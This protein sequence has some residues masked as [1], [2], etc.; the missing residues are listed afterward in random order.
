MP[1]SQRYADER[2]SERSDD[3]RDN[4]ERITLK[5]HGTSLGPGLDI[6]RPALF[7]PTPYAFTYSG[8]R[9]LAFAMRQFQA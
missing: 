4:Q 7:V 6:N 9:R 8:R 3:R 1:L 2:R 5:P